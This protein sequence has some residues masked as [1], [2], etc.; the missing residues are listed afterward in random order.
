MKVYFLRHGET[1]WN[2]ERL[3]QG[4]TPHTQL[5]SFGIRLAEMTREGFQ[6]EGISFDVVYSS[7][8]RRALQTAQIITKGTELKIRTDER[9]K[10]MNFGPYEG[11]PCCA[12]RYVDQNIAN[13]FEHPELFEPKGDGESLKQVADRFVDFFQKEILSLEGT[14][15]NVLVVSHGGI[16]RTSMRRYFL[17]AKYKTIPEFHQPNCCVHVLRI[18]NGDFS[19]EE[20]GKVFYSEETAKMVTEV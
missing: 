8:L 19:I 2:C 11:T 18:E 13:C 15:E 9:I 7:P 16:M 20:L 12:G 3:I 14:F 6:K 17:P 4:Q 1:S 10:E 5:T